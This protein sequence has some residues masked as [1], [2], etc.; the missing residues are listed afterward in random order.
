MS[1]IEP[2]KEVNEA[3]L[4]FEQMAEIHPNEEWENSLFLKIRQ[5]KKA[6]Q[7]T[8]TTKITALVAL[9]LILMNASAV[10]YF[11]SEK[12]NSSPTIEANYQTVSD[13]LFSIPQTNSQ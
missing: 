11:T 8:S 7:S 5:S 3:M 2:H 4:A 6:Q 1:N 13:E 10:F 12:A 9:T